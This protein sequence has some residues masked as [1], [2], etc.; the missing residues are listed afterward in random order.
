M[1][2]TEKLTLVDE[3]LDIFAAHTPYMR[4]SKVLERLGDSLT[5]LPVVDLQALKLLLKL[6]VSD[7]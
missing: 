5:R 6:I 3:I 7:L 4:N 2:A 1:G